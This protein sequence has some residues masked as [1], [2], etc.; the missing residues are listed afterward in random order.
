M[1]LA[2]SIRVQ[3]PIDNPCLDARPRR[4]FVPAGGAIASQF[5]RRLKDAPIPRGKRQGEHAPLFPA[6]PFFLRALRRRSQ[7]RQRKNEGGALMFWLFIVLAPFI[8]VALMR[9][10]FTPP[11]AACKSD[12]LDGGE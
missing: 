1:R 2:L 8:A 6:A 3:H 5:A 12:A 9:A 4:L 11:A 7:E 10:A